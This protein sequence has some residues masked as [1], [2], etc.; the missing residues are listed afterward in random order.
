MVFKQIFTCTQGT[1]RI[2]LEILFTE[3]PLF[4]QKLGFVVDS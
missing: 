2:R 1:N 4:Y 3:T